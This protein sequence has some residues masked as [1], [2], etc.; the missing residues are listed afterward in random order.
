M[1][2]TLADLAA[3][4]RAVEGECRENGVRP[5]NLIIMNILVNEDEPLINPT[6]LHDGRWMTNLNPRVEG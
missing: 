1:E 4:V 5:E 3:A 6:P 2:I